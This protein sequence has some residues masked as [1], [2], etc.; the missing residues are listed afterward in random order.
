MWVNTQV[1]WDIETGDILERHG[2]HYDGP[3]LRCCGGPSD[4]Q[5]QATATQGALNTELANQ[6]KT[7]AATVDPYATSLVTGGN[8]VFAQEEAQ[9]LPN[10]AAE[11]AYGTSGV[12]KNINQAKATQA[13]KFAGYGTALPSGFAASA[14]RDLDTSGAEAFDQNQQALIAAQEQAKLQ[15]AQLQQGAQTTGAQL[16]NP[17]AVAG[18]TTQGNATIP[19]LAPAN[20]FWGN[21]VSGLVQGAGNIPQAF[22]KKGGKVIRT[23]P[24]VVHRGEQ[25]L[26][27]KQQRRELKPQFA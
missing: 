19:S 2:F 14:A 7:S 26:T 22:A 8:P 25:I 20:S 3:I 12:A 6:Y 27:P 4:A 11:S 21:L 17:L 9:G 16:L 24:V 18:A 23:G 15:G 13:N 10:F 1:T 5:N